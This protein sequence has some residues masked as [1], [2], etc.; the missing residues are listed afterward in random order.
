MVT[1]VNAAV[2]PQT[3]HLV[4]VKSPCTKL[5]WQ[6]SFVWKKSDQIGSFVERDWQL[7]IAL[8]ILTDLLCNERDL[9][10]S[11]ALKIL[12]DLLCTELEWQLSIAMK[13]LTDLLCDERDWQ[14]SF[15]WKKIWSNRFFRWTRLIAILCLVKSDSYPLPRELKSDKLWC[16]R[17]VLTAIHCLENFQPRIFLQETQHPITGSSS[18]LY[19][20]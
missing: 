19:Q 1:I 16:L 2:C 10:L 13:I 3:S 20:I 15:V 7:S 5:D 6:L 14:L 18:H 12:I 17:E 8:K 9:Q 11:T 4:D